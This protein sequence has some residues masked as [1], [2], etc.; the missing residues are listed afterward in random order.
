MQYMLLIYG[1]ENGDSD[2]SETEQ[3]AECSRS[4]STTPRSCA[5]PAS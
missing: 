1:N 4:G 5:R 2:T 3:R